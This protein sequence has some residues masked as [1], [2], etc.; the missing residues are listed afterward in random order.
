MTTL[1][2]SGTCSLDGSIAYEIADA[3]ILTAQAWTGA[4]L[5]WAVIQGGTAIAVALVLPGSRRRGQLA[6]AV[7]SLRPSR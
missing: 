7:E 4:E 2:Y 6:L 3:I 5:A 1:I